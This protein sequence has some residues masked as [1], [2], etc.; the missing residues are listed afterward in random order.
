MKLQFPSYWFRLLFISFIPT[1][2]SS[3]E[4][5]F[6]VPAGFY[7]GDFLLEISS[8]T[9]GDIRYTL[10]NDD[11]TFES[12][13]FTQPILIKEKSSEANSISNIPTNPP[14]TDNSFVWKEPLSNIP[15]FRTVK[16]ALF[17]NEIQISEIFIEE[18]FIG[19]SLNDIK[20]PIF[21]IQADSSGLFGYEE[22][23][24]V[25]GKDYDD[26]PT[27]W[28]PGNY[29][30]NGNDWERIISLSYYKNQ[31]LI[32][33][34]RT[35]MEIHGGGSRIMPC[36][37]IRLNAK[38]SLGNSHFEYPIFEDRSHDKYKRLI[39]RNSGQDWNN[40]LFADILMHSLLKNQ[41]V[42]Y[43]A[44]NQVVVFVNGEYWG[45]HNLREK[46][47]KY[48]FENYH[49]VDNEEIDYLEIAMEFITK[50][51][52]VE[53]YENMNE[54]LLDLDLTISENYENITRFIDVENYI[55]HHISKIYSGCNDW[56]GN[57][58][59]I[60]RTQNKGSQW[61]WIGNDYDD[62]FK[63][64]EKDSYGHATRSDWYDWPNPE[65][66]TR[67][68]RSLMTNSNFA[69]MYKSRLKYHLDNTYNSARV[70]NMI[71]SLEVIYRPEMN[72]HI[73][74]WNYPSSK[75]DWENTIIRFKLFANRRAD[76]IWENFL[77]Y[78]PDEY[79]N[80]SEV[81]IYPNPSSDFITIELEN[82]WGDNAQYQLL[83]VRGELKIN[84]ALSSKNPNSVPLD[85]IPS[86]IYIMSIFSQKMQ[87]NYRFIIEN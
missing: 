50:E 13:L 61:R 76:L 51:G 10:N 72:R 26:N 34:Q 84:G 64:I 21:S 66:S 52:N 65:W 11:P 24:Y 54:S 58:E 17:N 83:S 29:F 6:T 55:D 60:W 43:Q 42:E 70:N 40:S 9:S 68:F 18:Y 82:E 71:D 53:D 78:F 19:S 37:S 22:G 56:S 45:I 46:Y 27:M 1:L 38:T 33:R 23:I 79:E 7:S 25:P 15:K 4:L 80:P 59:R 62:A 85:Y 77:E 48:Y 57:N 12:P 32:F 5:L 44:S 87:R 49:S 31:S 47:D 28:Q 16:A 2:L 20:L 73:Q 41:N 30:E 39:L 35:E 63:E 14:S 86:G 74:R 67:L 3:Q 75:S 8:S 36:K 69:L 81:K